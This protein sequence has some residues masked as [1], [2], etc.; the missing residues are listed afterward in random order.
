MI[1]AP[2]ALLI[3]KLMVPETGVPATLDNAGTLVERN[4][5]NVIYAAT[6]GALDGL[7]LALNVAA[8]LIVALALVAMVDA[9]LGLFGGWIGGWFGQSWD[10]S[11][12]GIF[13]Y[14]FAPSLG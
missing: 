9:I 5:G 6:D 2:A 14:V 7:R 3:A 13:G 1:S 4:H 8:M 10:W 11:L 12:S